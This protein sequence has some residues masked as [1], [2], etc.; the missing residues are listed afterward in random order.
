MLGLR[1]IEEVAYVSNV[2]E[3]VDD[4]LV[5]IL[6]SGLNVTLDESICAHYIWSIYLAHHCAEC[7]L[8]V[9]LLARVYKLWRG[10]VQLGILVCIRAIAD[11]QVTRHF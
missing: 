3:V 7:L 5:L 11:L 10:C 9:Y 4:N 1:V 6:G 8:A 2:F